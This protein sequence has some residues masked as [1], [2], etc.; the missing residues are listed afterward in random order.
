MSTLTVVGVQGFESISLEE[1]IEQA[2]LLTRVDRKYVVPAAEVGILMDALAGCARILEVDEGREFGYRSTYF[3][4]PQRD[5][6]LS[7][8]RS[9]RRRWKVRTRTYLDSGSSWL[10]V[11]TRSARDQT[12]KQ[13]IEH[14]DAHHLVDGLTPAGRSFVAPLLGPGVAA[15]VEPV[16]DTVYRRTT[17]FL[18]ASSSRATIDVHLRWTSLI[19]GTELERPAV[20]VIETKTGSTP[21]AVD[22]LMWSHRHRPVRISK[23]G[24]GMAALD[25][26]LPRLKWHRA[27]ARHLGLTTNTPRQGE[28]S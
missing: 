27:M 10:E 16:L 6:F 25:P 5:S 19:D 12:M 1:L 21:S 4:T 9:Q 8:G 13:R 28:N 18:P 11:K 15:S 17:L 3:D 7:A 26:Q 20:A 24:V 14:P 23:F 22:R 2:E